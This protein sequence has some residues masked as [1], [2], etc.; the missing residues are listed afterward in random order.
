M[1]SKVCA[2][3][4]KGFAAKSAR[5]RTCSQRCRTALSRRGGEVLSFP[6]SDS[7]V[8]EPVLVSRLRVELDAAGVG[9]TSEAAA[10]IALAVLAEDV[11]APAGA[12]VSAHK[13]LRA[14]KAAALAA[15]GRD[16]EV[17]EVTRRRDEKLAAARGA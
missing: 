1:P 7:G 8:E 11:S 2:N 12:R 6:A 4:G 17:D 13:E 3:C 9:G 14:A 10:A 15:S 16:D 5:A